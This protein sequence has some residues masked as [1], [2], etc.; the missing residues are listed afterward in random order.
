MNESDTM[1]SLK[2]NSLTTNSLTAINPGNAYAAPDG[3]HWL[4]TDYLGRDLLA[5]IADAMIGASLPVALAVAT[6]FMAAV[7]VFMIWLPRRFPVAVTAF[8][9]LIRSLPA[10]LIAFAILILGNGVQRFEYV[11]AIVGV[12]AGM[13]TFDLLINCWER[14]RHLGFWE[15]HQVMGGTARTRAW[16]FGILQGW[17]LPLLQLLALW[18]QTALALEAT[19]AYLGIGVQE[20]AASLGNI[21][22]AH[23]DRALKGYP[24]PAFAAV[25]ALV[26][27][28]M[29]PR[30]CI[31]ASRESIGKMR[32]RPATW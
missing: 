7:L 8:I 3:S 18:V 27:I 26:V 25:A 17:R 13:A 11:L 29:L 5:R 2:L 12:A 16:K 6:G 19:L 10:G 31:H 21:V 28:S 9:S 32:H 23:Y 30:L 20:P 24:I 1:S 4:G 15:A 22:A 14:D